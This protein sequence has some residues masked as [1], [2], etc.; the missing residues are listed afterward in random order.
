MAQTKK[1]K[2]DSEKIKM[3][4]QAELPLTVT[5]YTLPPEME[6][7]ISDVLEIFL[8]S[9]NQSHMFDSLSYC[10]K[11]L[12]NN[13]KKANTKRIYFTLKKLD[14]NNKDDYEKGMANFK[15][16]TINN[17]K[18]YLEEQRKHGYFIKVLFQTRNNKIKIEIK[19]KAELTYFEFKRIHDKI[20]RAQQFDTVE[21]GMLHLLDGSEGAGL[22]IAILVLVLRK[23]GLTEE[24]F[25]VLSEN[26]ETITRIILPVFNKDKE[27]ISL[28][29]RVFVNAIDGLPEFPENITRIN[30]LINDPNSNISD[31]A[32]IISNDVSLTGE[33]LKMVN[34]AAYV[35]SQPCRSINEAV[36]IAG[37]KG[38]RNLLY[39]I[40]CMSSMQQVSDSDNKKLWDHSYKVAFFSYEIA[41]QFCK[42]KSMVEDSYVC[43]LLHDM[44]KVVFENTSPTVLGKISEVCDNRNIPKSLIESLVAGMNHG[45][46]G[47]LIAEKWNFPTVLSG[48]IRSHHYPE[49]APENIR[50]LSKV[51]YLADMMAHFIDNEVE[52]NQFDE[53]LIAEF[54]IDSEEKLNDFAEK[55]KKK[56][57]S[58]KKI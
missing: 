35:L 28:L 6:E 38:I 36:K 18:Y 45:E 25:Q 48:V 11:E 37:I 1:I 57:L 14:L 17:I 53:R 19:N 3:A 54:E 10:V 56:F 26:G 7:Y 34:S 39:S 2:V 47:A 31:I 30:G 8:K 12:V 51:V 49:N 5:T 58:G 41:R 22:G 21:Q 13:A 43:G 23:I 29:T 40:G 42:D 27:E 20:T 52:Y 32:T 33:L 9:L 50:M 44:G 24:N 15:E 46:V 55:L 4:I 16:D